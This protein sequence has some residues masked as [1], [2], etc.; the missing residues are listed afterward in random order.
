MQNSEKHKQ[1]IPLFPKFKTSGNLDKLNST[2]VLTYSSDS[3]FFENSSDNENDEE[4][5]MNNYSQIDNENQI[6]NEVVIQKLNTMN[7]D[8]DKPNIQ[9]YLSPRKNT[10]DFK[11]IEDYIS[12]S[13]YDIQKIKEKNL[14]KINIP[15]N[16]NNNKEGISPNKK[17][18]NKII[19]DF[20][21]N[22]E[23][24]IE[25][26]GNNIKDTKIKQKSNKNYV[27]KSLGPLTEEDENSGSIFINQNKSIF[28]SVK[29]LWKFQKIL[30]GNQIIDIKSKKLLI[31]NI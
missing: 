2:A 3:D 18:N 13:G 25:T 20:F 26:T 17:N 6:N 31:I 8:I 29:E 7:I 22:N 21:I 1:K 15:K 23:G 4:F 16:N 14:K 12:K 30:L 11:D 28:N 24:D 19:N 10:D 9:S 5:N 27:M